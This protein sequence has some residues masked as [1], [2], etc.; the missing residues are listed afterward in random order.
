MKQFMTI[1]VLVCFAING[2]NSYQ[3]VAIKDVEAKPEEFLNQ[4]ALVHFEGT[5]AAPD[6][7]VRLR[8]GSIEY[9]MVS[10]E[11]ALDAKLYAATPE[12]S[13]VTLDLTKSKRVETYQ[14]SSGYT[15]LVALLAA[16][17]GPL[18]YDWVV[19]GGNVSR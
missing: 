4:K 15:A 2:C 3:D 17:F 5:A 14:F 13:N 16:T 6:S 11:Q 9:P 12:P 10:G 7:V 1:L 18:L 8:L 19:H